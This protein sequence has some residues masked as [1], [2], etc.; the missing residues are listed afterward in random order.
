MTYICGFPLRLVAHDCYAPAPTTERRQ[1]N[2]TV[3]I[4]LAHGGDAELDAVKMGS[5]VTDST[6]RI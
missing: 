4:S 2:D 6:L 3:E 1:N 5:G